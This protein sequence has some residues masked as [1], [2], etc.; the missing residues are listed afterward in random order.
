[1]DMN[2]SRMYNVSTYEIPD[3]AVRGQN[4]KGV[5]TR[6]EALVLRK[7]DTD[8]IET[9]HVRIPRRHDA[10]VFGVPLVQPTFK[11]FV[12]GRVRVRIPPLLPTFACAPTPLRSRPFS[13]LHH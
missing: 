12:F 2:D 1:M 5:I 10:V 7:Q 11:G 3:V 6:L 4:D 9:S 13:Q 8:S